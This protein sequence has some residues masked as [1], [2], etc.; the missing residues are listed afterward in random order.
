MG[1][2]RAPAPD[3]MLVPRSR[4]DGERQRRQGRECGRWVRAVDGCW[5]A[6]RAHLFGCSS[7]VWWGPGHCRGE[8]DHYLEPAGAE[9][10]CLK[11]AVVGSYDRSDIGQPKAD[12]LAVGYSLVEA[13]ERLEQRRHLG[14]GDHWPRI[15][16]R[17]VR[18]AVVGVC[19]RT[20]Y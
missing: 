16:D 9:G 14:L 19:A 4:P 8:P 13:G 17:K 10:V 7:V 15:G 1:T 3:L 6:R 5:S 18:L 12:A 2:A 11:V 20:A